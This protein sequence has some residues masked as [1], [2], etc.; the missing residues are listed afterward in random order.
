MIV[1]ML[2]DASLNTIVILFMQIPVFIVIANAKRFLAGNFFADIRNAQ[3]AFFKLPL[4]AC[5]L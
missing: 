4:L 5:F 3:A 2:N 1:F